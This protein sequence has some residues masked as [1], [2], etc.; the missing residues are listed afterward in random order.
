ML[1]TNDKALN[2]VS[3]YSLNVSKMKNSLLNRMENN[4][5]KAIKKIFLKEYAIKIRHYSKEA[6]YYLNEEFHIYI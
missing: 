4:K 5:Q 2:C 6:I 1:S 3:S